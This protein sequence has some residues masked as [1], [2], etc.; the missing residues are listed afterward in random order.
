MEFATQCRD[1]IVDNGFFAPFAAWF[2]QIH[3]AF[4]AV[5]IAFVNDKLHA[6]VSNL[7]VF[8]GRRGGKRSCIVGGSC[9]FRVHERV[10]TIGTE[11]VEFMVASF[12]GLAVLAC[13][14]LVLY[15]NVALVDDGRATVEAAFR[16]ELVVVKVTV[17]QTIVLVERNM[18]QS[19]GTVGTHEASRMEG[20]VERM[21]HFACNP[22][23]TCKAACTVA[24]D[25]RH[26]RSIRLGSRIG[27]GTLS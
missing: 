17:W 23:A 24:A 13:Q 2:V 20:R 8:I 6:S 22:L 25:G 14:L 9:S 27:I 21:Y 3:V 1:E 16:K 7:A 26:G 4:L 11:E 12:L 19:F 10:S 5:R 15:G 18:L